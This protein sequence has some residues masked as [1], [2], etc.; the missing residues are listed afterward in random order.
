M[1]DA[2]RN[3]AL[4]STLIICTGVLGIGSEFLQGLIPDNGREFDVWDIVANTV[5]S[6]SALALSS[7]YHKRMLER[8][9]KKRLDKI[10]VSR[11]IRAKRVWRFLSCVSTSWQVVV[12]ATD[13]CLKR[14]RG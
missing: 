2:S 5:G 13:G 6:L 11:F 10:E 14:R 3:R 8:K 12:A 9:R 4:K 7:W 1:L